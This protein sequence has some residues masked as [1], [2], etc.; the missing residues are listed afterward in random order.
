MMNSLPTL[1]VLVA[2]I[3]AFTIIPS[4]DARHRRRRSAINFLACILI[5]A[6]ALL[7]VAGVFR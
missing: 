6:G 7:F 3:G 4:W 2:G 5:A 1:G